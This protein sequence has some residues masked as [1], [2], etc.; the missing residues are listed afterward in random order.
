MCTGDAVLFSTVEFSNA[1][2]DFGSVMCSYRPLIRCYLQR[3]YAQI[4][5]ML[6]LF[7]LRLSIC[8][9]DGPL[10]VPVTAGVLIAQE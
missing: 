2:Q 5:P 4:S 7:A 8:A 9:N 3:G 6:F 10:R 1:K